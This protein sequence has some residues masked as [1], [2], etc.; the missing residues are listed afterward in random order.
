M[1]HRTVFS[2]CSESQIPI[3]SAELGPSQSPSIERKVRVNV[4]Q[5]VWMSLSQVAWKKSE[6]I[7]LCSMNIVLHPKEPLTMR[8]AP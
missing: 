4:P 7:L 3:P 2:V 1:G 6:E 5:R 8:W